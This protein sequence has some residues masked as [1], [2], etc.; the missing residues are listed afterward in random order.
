M[1]KTSLILFVLLNMCEMLQAQQQSPM[2]SQSGFDITAHIETHGIPSLVK[3]NQL[4][5]NAEMHFKSKRYAQALQSYSEF[6]LHA[7]ALSLVLTKGMQPY[8]NASP[9]DRRGYPYARLK[10][11]LPMEM[12][13][14]ALQRRRGRG[15]VMMGHC[16]RELGRASEAATAYMMGLELIP[17]AD[18]KLW[19]EAREGLLSILGY[20]F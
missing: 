11:L 2:H 4:E 1:K 12:E 8:Y 9:E 14:A 19:A 17:L 16:Q 6:V 13:A 20:S 15:Y 18:E 5:K 3:V 7:N 10:N